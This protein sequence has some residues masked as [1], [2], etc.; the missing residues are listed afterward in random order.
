MLLLDIKSD[1]V[2]VRLIRCQVSSIFNQSVIKSA[3]PVATKKLK[4]ED[5]HHFNPSPGK[6]VVFE[7]GSVITDGTHE[8]ATC[9]SVRELY[10]K[11]TC[12][13]AT[14]TTNVAQL[15]T[16][17]SQWDAEQLNCKFTEE[18][19]FCGDGTKWNSAAELCEI[20]E[21]V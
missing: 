12:C 17:G 18:P 5:I 11:H 9:G 4:T 2:T 16:K 19:S 8:I 6:R 21:S 10:R 14:R 3:I 1:F 20:D 7:L 15:C 13:G